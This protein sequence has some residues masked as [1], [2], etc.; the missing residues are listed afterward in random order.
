MAWSIC[1]SVAAE[2]KLNKSKKRI[3]AQEIAN[4][5]SVPINRLLNFVYS[6]Q[7]GHVRVYTKFE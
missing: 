7:F 4:E 6:S 2:M 5:N 3:Q 1:Y